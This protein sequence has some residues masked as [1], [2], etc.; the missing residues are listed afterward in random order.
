MTNLH[1]LEMRMSAEK[2]VISTSDIHYDFGLQMRNH[3]N[4]ET[5]EQ[6]ADNIS[7][8]LKENQIAIVSVENRLGE[9]WY[10]VDGFHRYH[11]A[12]AADVKEIDVLF[13]KGNYE[14]AV[15]YAMT[16]NWQ[17]G[18]RPSKD[19]AQ[20]SLKI[21]LDTAPDFGYDSKQVIKWLTTFGIPKSTAGN[22]TKELRSDI[23]DKRDA[24]ILRLSAEGLSDV[25]IGK[26]VGC[27][28]KTVRSHIERLS[29]ESEPAAQTPSAAFTP[30]FDE[31]EC[32]TTP[33]INPADA[34]KKVMDEL[35][36]EENETPKQ[37]RTPAHSM[38]DDY[39]E[40]TPSEEMGGAINLLAEAWRKHGPDAL[41]EFC[42]ESTPTRESNVEII[43]QI[44]EFLKAERS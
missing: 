35:E 44:A 13:M 19:D 23:D 25:A 8:I 15:R 43:L 4:Q 42:N 2:H 31:S 17:N 1:I 3:M 11:A 38:P 37:K 6:Y 14:D 36:A 26:E 34:F 5:V 18:L 24:E 32:D 22:N 16:A 21:L 39:D 41:E 27:T 28:D 40:Y 7:E 33:A 10:I 12:L 9:S 29:S 30:F 20:R